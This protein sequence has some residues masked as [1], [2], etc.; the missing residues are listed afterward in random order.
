M[1]VAVLAGHS[2]SSTPRYQPRWSIQRWNRSSARAYRPL[3]H[4][5]RAVSCRSAAAYLVLGI[6]VETKHIAEVLAPRS[7]DMHHVSSDT[8][9]Q[10]AVAA[11]NDPQLRGALDNLAETFSKRRLDAIGSVDDWEG[12]RDQARSIKD[13]VLLHLDTYLEQF[14]K[15]A[16]AAGARVHWARDGE[17][18][19][20]T[21]L[22][23]IEACQGVN[24]VK[25]KSMVTEEIGLNDALEAAGLDPVE[26]DLGEWIIQLAE[27][28]PSHIVVPAIHKTKGT[29]RRPFY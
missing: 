2:R 9:H 27:E 15:N 13:E 14:S 7:I 3:L 18:A 22:A 11:L 29:D 6:K 20:R 5:M 23:I 28:T 16:E 21:V 10:N 24:I 19:C 25:S 8:F 17:E 1:S 12:L 26:T 4:A